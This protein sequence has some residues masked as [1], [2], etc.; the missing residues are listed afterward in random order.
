M[1]SLKII[2]EKEAT[3]NR[4]FTVS[5]V[6]FAIKSEMGFHLN[7]TSTNSF[8]ENAMNWI[9]IKFE[10]ND[11]ISLVLGETIFLEDQFD[12]IA[13]YLLAMIYL[14]DSPLR[15]C[16]LDTLLILRLDNDQIVGSLDRS[17][18]FADHVH[19]GFN[20]PCLPCAHLKLTVTLS[21]TA[22]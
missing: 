14:W 21:A 5:D 22:M 16:S 9:G 1:A 15:S 20:S 11:F 13:C 8:L 3:L 12:C 17:L 7:R 18:V 4:P 19:L 6:H 10:A 2:S